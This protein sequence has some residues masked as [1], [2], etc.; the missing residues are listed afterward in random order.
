MSNGLKLGEKLT[1]ARCGH[2]WQPRVW[3]VQKC[4][5]CQ[6]YKYQVQKPQEAGR[7]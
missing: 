1:C 5:K 6:S 2:V 3:P 7:Q 4:P